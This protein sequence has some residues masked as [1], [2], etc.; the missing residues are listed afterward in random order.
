MIPEDIE[1]DAA[2]AVDIGVVDLGGER[3][4]GG[5]EGV[6]GREGNG[7]EKDTARVGRVTRPHDRRLPLEHVVAGGSSAARR[8]R[9]TTEVSELLQKRSE[10]EMQSVF[11]S[12][13]FLSGYKLNVL[14][15]ITHLVDPFHSHVADRYR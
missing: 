8:R 15:M 4:L 5:L 11:S 14:G 13:F 10:Q 2:V 12:P 6:V 1:T 3:D 7:E 9:V